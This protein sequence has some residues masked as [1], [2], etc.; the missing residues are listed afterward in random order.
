M[1][2]ER[3]GKR[4]R[5]GNGIFDGRRTRFSA[6]SHDMG[7][8]IHDCKRHNGPPFKKIV[9]ARFT[10]EKSTDRAV[11]RARPIDTKLELASYERTRGGGTR[12]PFER[13]A[14]FPE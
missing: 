12:L 11:E 9:N 14:H 1:P 13:V 5:K 8:V 4:T 10:K 2:G 7:R 3:E 6:H